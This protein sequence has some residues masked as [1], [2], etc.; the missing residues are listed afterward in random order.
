MKHIIK[1]IVVILALSV[2]VSCSP[3][4]IADRMQQNISVVAVENVTGSVSGGWVITLRMK[5]GTGYQP[6]LQRAE[7]DIFFD[8]SLTAHASLMAPITLPKNSEASIDIPVEITIHNSIKALSL[9]LRLSSKDFNGV[10]LSL[11]ATVCLMGVSKN[12]SFNKLSV[13]Q[14]LET[15]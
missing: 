6:T 1:L 9:L 14:L 11:D 12:L 8:N 5:N 15:L 3:K 13:K 4:K 7:A 2:S 10:E